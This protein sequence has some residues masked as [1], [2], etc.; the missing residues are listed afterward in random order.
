M[1]GAPVAPGVAAAEVEAMTDSVFAR[2]LQADCDSELARELADE[3]HQ[4]PPTPATVAT[5]AA[6]TTKRDEHLQR[7]FTMGF[8][9]RER[10]C[11]LLDKMKDDINAVVQELI[12]ED[13]AGWKDGRH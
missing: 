3:R 7:L 12:N 6:P 2:K 5:A 8:F 1:G 9:N 10:N 4:P 11:E 13:D